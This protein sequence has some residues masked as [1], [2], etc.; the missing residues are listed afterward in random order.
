MNEIKLPQQSVMNGLRR[1]IPV[2]DIEAIK[3]AII[4]Y[5]QTGDPSKPVG[6]RIDLMVGYK[7][8]HYRLRVGN[9]RIPYYLETK[10]GGF[11]V[12]ILD[13]VH[14]KEME[15]WLKIHGVFK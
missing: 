1:K 4:K 2:N 9:Y 14:K 6:R 7:I 15:I 10:H 13:A 11:T 8:P 5:L 3:K 12:Y